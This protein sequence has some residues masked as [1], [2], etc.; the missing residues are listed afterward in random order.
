MKRIDPAMVLTAQVLLACFVVVTV[1][2]LII[3][4]IG[5]AWT[6]DWWDFIALWRWLSHG[7]YWLSWQLGW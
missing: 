4:L 7:W 2:G 5:A 1:F 3:S 6:G